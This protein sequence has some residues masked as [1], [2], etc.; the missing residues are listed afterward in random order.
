MGGLNIHPLFGGAADTDRSDPFALMEVL[1]IR[2]GV[3]DYCRW[4]AVQSPPLDERTEPEIIRA[5]TE[6]LEQT[7]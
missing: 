1:I 2:M 6:K 4:L 5:M 7:P 3:E